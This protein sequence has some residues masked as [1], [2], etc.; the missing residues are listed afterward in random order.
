MDGP[1]AYGTTW[2][3]DTLSAPAHI[4]GTFGP[5]QTESSLCTN[6]TPSCPKPQDPDLLI[7]GSEGEFQQGNDKASR[8]TSTAMRQ[9]K[10]LSRI[11]IG[12]L[13]AKDM[14]VFVSLAANDDT[15]STALAGGAGVQL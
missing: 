7:P 14:R 10:Q 11:Q 13:P 6:T 5:E 12:R 1:P 8:R 9:Q 3:K 15:P 2:P 4:K